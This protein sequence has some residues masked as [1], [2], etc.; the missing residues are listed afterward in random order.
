MIKLIIFSTI[1][2]L[3]T[4][5]IKLFTAE[6]TEHSNKG[7]KT[8]LTM[9]LMVADQTTEGNSVSAIRQEMKDL[10]SLRSLQVIYIF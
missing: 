8:E 10:V 5:V 6:Q 2:K 1:I 9:L 4:Y 3:S 7:I